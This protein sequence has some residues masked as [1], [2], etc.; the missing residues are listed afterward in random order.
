MSN[1]ESAIRVVV[2]ES[3]I[4]QRKE[5]DAGQKKMPIFGIDGPCNPEGASLIFLP[6]STHV[7]ALAVMEKSF[8]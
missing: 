6:S 2:V 1:K 5:I 4:S 7:L 3:H 8:L